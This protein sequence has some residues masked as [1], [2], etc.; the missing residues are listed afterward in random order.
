MKKCYMLILL[1]TSTITIKSNLQQNILNKKFWIATFFF[2]F[3]EILVSNLSIW[4]R[5]KLQTFSHTLK[6]YEISRK[7][8]RVFCHVLILAWI[9][10]LLELYRFFVKLSFITIYDFL[11]LV[12]IKTSN[13]TK[14]FRFSRKHNY[15]PLHVNALKIFLPELLN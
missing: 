8:V 13:W 4:W 6:H 11:I 1:V 15:E 12:L 7:K 5:L 10:Y 9:N 3:Q 14:P 2:A